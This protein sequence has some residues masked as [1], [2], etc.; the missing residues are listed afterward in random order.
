MPVV[1]TCEEPAC[2]QSIE[3]TKETASGGFRYYCPN[4]KDEDKSEGDVKGS[5]TQPPYPSSGENR[6][7]DLPK[8]EWVKFATEFASKLSD[9]K[10]PIE[11]VEN[12][13]VEL[14][15]K[16]P[17]KMVE[18]EITIED[19]ATK[20]DPRGILENGAETYEEKNEDYG[21]SW[22][23]AG[24]VLWKLSEGGIEVE[25]EEEA[26]QLGLYFQRLHKLTR[27]FN[28]EFGGV[29]LNNEPTTDSHKDAMVYAAM[30][31]SLSEE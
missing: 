4:H 8:G 26:I 28:G 23:Q 16:E 30:A 15:L 6:E 31:A 20:S 10:V 29:D 18:N 25:S 5:D 17:I 9:K 22:R 11:D 14:D 24:E 21:E 2:I 19:T 7:D 27:G 1:L 3:V 13:E 12:V